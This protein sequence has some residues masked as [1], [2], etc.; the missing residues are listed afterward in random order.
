M[1]G[2]GKYEGEFIGVNTIRCYKKG[3]TVIRF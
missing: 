1:H 2:S 3:K